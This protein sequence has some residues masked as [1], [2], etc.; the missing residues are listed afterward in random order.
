MS[1]PSGNS[2]QLTGESLAAAVAIRVMGWER[3][4]DTDAQWWWVTPDGDE[5]WDEHYRVSPYERVFKIS[6][7]NP[8]AG[9]VWMPH[10]DIAQAWEVKDRMLSLGYDFDYEEEPSHGERPIAGFIK[11]SDSWY[12]QHESAATAICKAAIAAVE[13]RG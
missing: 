12:V 1:E 8:N 6:Q 10:E 7:T 13:A 4:Q 5:D 9:A 11:G 2:G 3:K